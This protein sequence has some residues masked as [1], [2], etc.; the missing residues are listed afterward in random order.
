MLTFSQQ[1]LDAWLAGF[2]LPFVRILALFSAAPLFSLRSVPVRVRIVASAVM[3]MLVAPLLPQPV[4]LSLQSAAGLGLVAQQV[5]IG[6]SIGIAARLIFA[7]FEVAGEFIG[8][9]MGFSFAGFFDPHGGSQ[10]AVGSWLSTLAMLVFLSLNAHL[11]V[12]D[13][14][15]ASFRSLPIAP[16]PIA[17]LAALRLERLG[18]DMFRLALTL[19]LPA[20]VLMLFINLVMGLASRVA[21]QLS[22]F[23]VGFPITVTLGLML[24][25]LSTG[26]LSQAVETGIEVFLGGMR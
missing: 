17:A 14:L 19:A 20:S 25:A 16:D 4:G 12:L 21:P 2:F 15:L 26:Q 13:A 6:L 23:A 24:L 3:A 22:I 7:V 10:S 1:A 8:L 18:G 5:A 9:Q 11:L